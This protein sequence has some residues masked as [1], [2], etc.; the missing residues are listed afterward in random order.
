M[1]NRVIDIPGLPTVPETEDR[2]LFEFL[3]AVKNQ[4]EV[5][6]G[7][8]T[9]R[10]KVVRQRD[11]ESLGIDLSYIP[12]GTGDFNFPG[13][14]TGIGSGTSIPGPPTNLA[15]DNQVFANCLTWTNPTT[16]LTDVSHIEIWAA[17]N[18]NNRSNA[19]LVGAW[20]WDSTKTTGSF[21]HSA[22]N[23]NSDYYYWVRTKTYG[24]LYSTWEPSG[25]GGLVSPASF[26]TVNELWGKLL[27]DS[28][29]FND[30]YK[31]IASSFQVIQPSST[32][33]AYASG[34]TYGLGDF[35]HYGGDYYQSLQG[36][37][38]G[39]QP[40]VS[41]TWWEQ[42]NASSLDVANP[43]F[44][45]GNIAGSPTV[46]IR[47]ELIVDGT[48]V[49]NAVHAN[50]LTANEMASHDISTW[51]LK[52]GN[53]SAGASGYKIDCDPGSGDYGKAEFNNITINFNSWA[54]DVSGTGVP[55]ANADVTSTELGYTASDVG[56]W[57]NNP[58][59]RINTQTTTIAGSKIT[60]GSV[61][62]T[63]LVGT[64]LHALYAY[65]GQLYVDDDLTVQSTGSIHSQ[66]KDSYTDTT[67]GWWMGYD[68]GSYKFNLGN[69]SY[70]I[71]W[72]GSILEIDGAVVVTGNVQANN[73]TEIQY[74]SGTNA[75]PAASGTT[76]HD[77]ASCS[78]LG[79][80]AY[81][82]IIWAFCSFESDDYDYTSK[83]EFGI[84][85]GTDTTPLESAEV[86]L[87][88]NS[89][90]ADDPKGSCTLI[91]SHDPGADVQYYLKI[92]NKAHSCN[93]AGRIVAQELK[94]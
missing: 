9:I 19:L 54:D 77:V 21:T 46:G 76:W 20:M 41:A 4:L 8:A 43:I 65:T 67:A 85:K 84:F 87:S 17:V 16:N 11:L 72:T 51:T 48:I 5:D 89:A 36:S 15:V 75:S 1:G 94:R 35:C 34:D 60:T 83:A 58:A 3:T 38:T 55:A 42:V 71:K 6:N 93:F 25:A 13:E 81:E 26:V 23:I 2:Q 63:Q 73:I 7:R 37:N 31:I 79:A 78:A 49:A 45:V 44:M 90:V 50:T 12:A 61:T 40:D 24:G 10:E 68:G 39:N 56:S 53:Y 52:S 14:G 91:Y 32:I 80:D 27:D 28:A 29:Y 22:L 47:G 88:E 59:S 69:S 66:N 70:S 57:S 64:D 92:R 86:Y 30:T 82:V 18:S 62:A 74:G 33:N